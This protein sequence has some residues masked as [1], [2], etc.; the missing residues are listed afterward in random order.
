MADDERWGRIEAHME[1]QSGWLRSIDGK[2]DDHLTTP[3]ADVADVK[4]NTRGR[5]MV[6]GAIALISLL[7]TIMAMV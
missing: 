7:G 5:Y 2:L 4:A 6:I 3:H 1:N